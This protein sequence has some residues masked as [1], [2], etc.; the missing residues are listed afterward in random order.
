[1]ERLAQIPLVDHGTLGVF[2]HRREL[3]AV[4]DP[5]ASRDSLGQQI[6]RGDE[7]LCVVVVR[8]DRGLLGLWIDRARSA[9]ELDAEAARTTPSGAIGKQTDHSID[10]RETP[11]FDLEELWNRTRRTVEAFYDACS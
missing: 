10:C 4:L 6:N 2:A 11:P 9:I 5:G 8:C 3:I 7:A 1:M